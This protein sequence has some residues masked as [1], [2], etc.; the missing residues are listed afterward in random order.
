MSSTYSILAQYYDAIYAEKDYKAE[1]EVLHTLIQAN[2]QSDGNQLLDAACGTGG[3]AQYLRRYYKITGM[4]IS[5]EMLDVAR[6]KFDD[7]EFYEG[8]ITEFTLHQEFDV[9]T[10]LFGSICYLTSPEALYRAIQC[11][12]D[13]TKEGGVVII[14]PIFTAE[15]FRPQLIGIT[16]V[17]ESEYKLARVSAVTRVDN[18]AYLNFHYV[19]ATPAGIQHI[20]DPSPM[21]IFARSDFVSAMEHAGLDVISDET[22]LNREAVFLGVKQ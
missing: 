21:G 8:D 10:C 22:S 18:I 16:C 15:S 9:I 3:H 14:E 4:D 6:G 19:L 2:K 20:H 5:T 17:D 7:I 1:V 11:F 13:H 12:S